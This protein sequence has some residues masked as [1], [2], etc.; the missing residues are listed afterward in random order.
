MLLLLL[1]AGCLAQDPGFQLQ[2]QESVT[3]Q[4]GLCVYVPCNFSYPQDGWTDST[5][6][7]GYWFQKGA[8]P[9]QHDPVATNNPGRKVQEGTKGRFQLLGD[10]RTY[11]CSLYIRD[12]Q[13]RDTGTYFFRVERGSYAR[14]NYGQTQLSV[15]VTDLIPD[16]QFQDILE[17][18]HPKNVTC[19]MPWACEWETPP[20][21]S[22]VRVNFTSLGP[23]TPDSSLVTLTPTPQ[24]HGA[25]LTC[26]VTLQGG[27][28]RE[29]TI[30]L[31]V[32]Y[33]PR[34][35]TVRVF[36][37]NSTVPEVLGNATSLRVQEG[38]SLRLVCETDGNPPARLSWSR[39]SVTLSPSKALNPG[40]LELPQVV[41]ADGGEFTCRA[42]HP[43]IS[44]HVSLSLAVQGVSS[45]CPQVC[46][47]QKGSWPL[48]LTLIRGAL[49]GT[50]FLLTY[51]LTWLYYTRLGAPRGEVREE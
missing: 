8:Y 49:M 29:K 20:V 43:R 50:G 27:K 44:Y 13:R 3:V 36:R 31:N 46:G 23:Q 15:H 21:F 19:M 11:N 35:L 42:Q 41:L 25:N 16:I 22:W 7:L 40:V 9:G 34:N 24:D 33:A 6:A 18:G 37:G 30:Q 1:R 39:G 17:A 38:Q 14:Y 45:S 2:V 10:P 26:R 32:S 12:A 5:P 48:V 47:E 28:I 4:E 51:G